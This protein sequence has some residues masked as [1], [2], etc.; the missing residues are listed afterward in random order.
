LE[1]LTA[2]IGAMA[3]PLRVIAG[4]LARGDSLGKAQ[5]LARNVQ[6]LGDRFHD[7]GEFHKVVA[8]PNRTYTTRSIETVLNRIR[9]LFVKANQIVPYKKHNLHKS[10]FGTTEDWRW[11]LETE[12]QRLDVRKQPDLYRLA[13]IYSQH[14]KEQSPTARRRNVQTGGFRGEKVP[15]RLLKSRRA[16]VLKHVKC[17]EK[18]ISE[19]YP[20][21]PLK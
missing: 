6:W 9:E 15:S 7:L 11:F 3:D 1:D 18:W 20:P 21:G 17:I 10:Y 16:T 4:R 5:Q 13:E 12:F 14:L 8:I 19:I 2:S